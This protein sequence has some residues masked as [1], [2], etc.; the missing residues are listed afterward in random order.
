VAIDADLTVGAAAAASLL[1]KVLRHAL[2]LALKEAEGAAVGSIKA[3]LSQAIK[4][5]FGLKGE[6]EK[7]FER[8]F[9]K[10]RDE[11]LRLPG[12]RLQQMEWLEQLLDG[13]S[14]ASE[15]FAEE[16]VE[17]HLFGRREARRRLPFLYRRAATP[18]M[19]AWEEFEPVVAEFFRLL[20]EELRLSNDYHR[21]IF[22]SLAAE[23]TAAAAAAMAGTVAEG[24][25]GPALQVIPTAPKLSEEEAEAAR[26]RYCAQLAER[27]QRLEFLGILTRGEERPIPLD[28]IFVDLRVQREPERRRTW[29]FRLP[30]EQE[31][32]D[33]ALLRQMMAEPERTYPPVLVHQAMLGHPRLVLI[34][35]PGSGKSTLTRYLALIF[36]RGQAAERLGIPEKRLPLLIPLRDYLAERARHTGDGFS[37]LDFLYCNAEEILN[38]DPPLPGGFFEHFLRRGECLVLFDGLDEV[39]ELSERIAVRDAVRSFANAFPDNRYLVTSRPA[40]YDEAPL[41]RDDSP[42][43]TSSTS[44]MTR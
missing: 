12:P 30:E 27:C 22:D 18:Q 11:F 25:R 13:K 28:K 34:G 32:P 8:A 41:P 20:R 7:A 36:A 9:A 17:A 29:A 39:T 24:E 23:R 6:E 4:K 33:E 26:E 21:E 37:F 14:P 35:A 5:L 1:W 16:A 3:R 19:P 2:E 31:V 38:V 43:S 44:P 15:E 10:A 40:G 42:T